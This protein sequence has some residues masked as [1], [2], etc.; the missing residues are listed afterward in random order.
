MSASA[1][2]LPSSISPFEPGLSAFGHLGIQPALYPNCNLSKAVTLA[3]EELLTDPQRAR[4]QEFKEFVASNVEPFVEQWDR[5]QKHPA[6]IISLLGKSGY[7]GSTLPLEYGGKGW[8][9]VTFGLLNE[10]LGRGSSSLTDL[11]TVQAMVSMTLLKW[12]TDEQRKT[13]IP[14]LAKGELIGAFALTEPGTGS[15][16]QSLET[17]FR[18]KDRKDSLIVNGEK[19]WISYGQVAGLFLVFGKARS[20]IRGL[21]RSEENCR[22]RNRTDPGNARLQGGRFGPN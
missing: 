21:S 4:Y 2:A 18:R 8:D 1:E 9:F 6:S 5:D 12:G 16:I 15:A 13:W 10:A 20:K 17:E 14:P 7:L 11:V 22:A 19:K 3:M